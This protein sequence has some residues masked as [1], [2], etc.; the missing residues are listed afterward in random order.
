MLKWIRSLFRFS[1]ESFLTDDSEREYLARRE[2]LGM[3]DDDPRASASVASAYGIPVV[4]WMS[5]NWREWRVEDRVK[6]AMERQ[7]YGMS[8]YAMKEPEV[9]P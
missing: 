8:E 3:K 9:L 1:T 5:K 7:R 2:A 6:Q 4:A